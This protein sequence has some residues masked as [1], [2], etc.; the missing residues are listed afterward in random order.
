M[1]NHADM[2]VFGRN[3]RVYFATSK[4]CTLSPFLPE[5]S[6]QFDVPIVTGAIAVDLENGSTMILIFGQGLWF[7][8]KMDKSLSF[9]FM[10]PHSVFCSFSIEVTKGLVAVS[11]C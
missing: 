11:T 8:D 9:Q 3:F 1:D 7:K 4:K 5:Y 6:E 10:G 2:H